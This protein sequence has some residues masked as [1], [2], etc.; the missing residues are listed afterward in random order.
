MGPNMVKAALDLNLATSLKYRFRPMKTLIREVLNLY[1][2]VRLSM[3]A[4][5]MKWLKRGM[6][7][8]NKGR[9]MPMFFMKKNY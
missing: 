3:V 1:L 9:F 5:D 8:T 6:G 4:R 7:E 2:V